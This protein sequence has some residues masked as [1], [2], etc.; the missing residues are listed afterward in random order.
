MKS[1]TVIFPEVQ[2]T[3]EHTQDKGI[4]R[5]LGIPVNHSFVSG[6]ELRRTQLT[7]PRPLIQA[8]YMKILSNRVIRD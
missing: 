7:Q 8:D 1:S 2:V 6:Y 5:S 3:E 4:S